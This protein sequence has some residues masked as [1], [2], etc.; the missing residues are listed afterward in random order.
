MRILLRPVRVRH[1]AKGVLLIP[2]SPRVPTKTRKHS[3]NHKVHEVGEGEP[4]GTLMEEIHM[5]QVDIVGQQRD[6]KVVRAIVF[7]DLTWSGDMREHAGVVI[8]AVDPD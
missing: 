8:V 1:Q 3:A 2:E 4:R 6:V 5:L 7:D